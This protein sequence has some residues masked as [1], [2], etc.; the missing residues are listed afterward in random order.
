MGD[1]K[2]KIKLPVIFD[3]VR[4]DELLAK[5]FCKIVIIIKPGIKKFI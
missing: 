5:E 3:C 1:N 2:I 4:L